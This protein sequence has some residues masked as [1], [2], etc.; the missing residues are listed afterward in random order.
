[1]IAARF[2]EYL[3][4]N[5]L[6]PLKVVIQINKDRNKAGRKGVKSHIMAITEIINRAIIRTLPF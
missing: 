6:K 2:I 5:L 1:M 3:C 4:D